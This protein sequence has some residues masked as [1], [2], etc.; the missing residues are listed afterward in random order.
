MQLIGCKTCDKLRIP[1]GQPWV[2]LTLKMS[3]QPC[4][5]CNTT[6]TEEQSYHFC[7]IQCFKEYLNSG[8]FEPI[9]WK[10]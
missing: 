7:S 2:E 6:A 1:F 3:R 8:L 10:E 9:E 5:A 4:S